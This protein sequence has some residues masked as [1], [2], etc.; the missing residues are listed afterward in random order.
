[1]SDH[2]RE[3]WHQPKTGERCSC[4]RG[5][6]RDNCPACEGTGWRVDFAAIRQRTAI[7]SV[8]T[9]DMIDAYVEHADATRGEIW[10][11]ESIQHAPHK[12]EILPPGLYHN[13]HCA[14]CREPIRDCDACGEFFHESEYNREASTPP[15]G[16]DEYDA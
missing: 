2:L 9:R 13:T 1:M 16:C 10:A 14:L 4:R 5:V 6:Q 15:C 11:A 12:P 3:P 8:L 7:C